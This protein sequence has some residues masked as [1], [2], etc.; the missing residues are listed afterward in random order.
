MENRIFHFTDYYGLDE[1]N[2]ISISDMWNVLKEIATDVETIGLEMTND[3]K[4]HLSTYAKQRTP[5]IATLIEEGK[6]NVGPDA[7]KYCLAGE[8]LSYCSDWMNVSGIT[9]NE[10]VTGLTLTYTGSAGEHQLLKAGDLSFSMTVRVDTYSYEMIITADRYVLDHDT[11]TNFLVTVNTYKNETELIDSFV[12][13]S[14]ATYSKSNN[15][16]SY[17]TYPNQSNGTVYGINTTD[18]DKTSRL[19]ATWA[20]EYGTVSNS[21]NFT[22]KHVVYDFVWV[23]NELSGITKENAYNETQQKTIAYTSN[24]PS[25]TLENKTTEWVSNISLD[26]TLGVLKYT[27]RENIG[28]ETLSATYNIL[29]DNVVVGYITIVQHVIGIRTFL[30]N[31]NS[32]SAITVTIGA[33][34]TTKS[35]LEDYETNYSGIQIVPD[36]TYSWITSKNISN[37]NG[38]GYLSATTTENT[39][40]N[41]DRTANLYI[42]TGSTIGAS[43]GLMKIVQEKSAY[44]PTFYWYDS[45]T[46]SATTLTVN[47]ADTTTG[48]IV[49]RNNYQGITWQ[50][51]SSEANWIT[52]VTLTQPNNDGNFTATFN[53]NPDTQDRTGRINIVYTGDNSVVGT[54]DI[55]QKEKHIPYTFYWGG[56]GT[57]S[58]TTITIESGDTIATEIYRNTY[59]GFTLEVAGSSSWIQTATASNYQGSGTFSATCQPNETYADR[60]EVVNV[61]YD[62]NTVGTIKVTQKK[63]GTYEFYWGNSNLPTTAVTVNSGIVSTYK[64][65]TNTYPNIKVSALTDSWVTSAVL[66][67]P[68]GGGRFDLTFPENLHTTDRT[69]E[70]NILYDNGSEDTLIGTFNLTQRKGYFLFYWVDVATSQSLTS[71]TTVGVASSDTSANIYYFNTYPEI[72]SNII[73]SPWITGATLNDETGHAAYNG[74]MQTRFYANADESPRNGQINITYSGETVGMAKLTQSGATY[75]FYWG[76]TGT[77]TTTGLTAASSDTSVSISYRNDYPGISLSVPSQSWVNASITSQNGNG[78]FNAQFSTNP[79]PADRTEN[80]SVMYGNKEVG[81]ITITQMAREEHHFYWQQTGT[82]TTT[83]VTSSSADT[84]ITILYRNNYQGITVSVPTDSWITSATVDNPYSDGEFTAYFTVNPD[85]TSRTEI[86]SIKYNN[87]EIAT[88]TITQERGYYYFYWENS[89][90]YYDTYGFNR[91]ITSSD[92]PY[93]S[94][95]DNLSAEI[96]STPWVNSVTLT[97]IDNKT[98]LHF[99]NTVNS[100]TTERTGAINIKHGDDV[101]GVLNLIQSGLS[102]YFNWG[103]TIDPNASAY[104]YTVSSAS[105][106]DHM[107]YVNNYPSIICVINDVDIYHDASWVTNAYLTSS[108]SDGI[109]YIDFDENDTDEERIAQINIMQGTKTVGTYKITQKAGETPTEPSFTVVWEDNNSNSIVVNENQATLTAKTNSVLQGWEIGNVYNYGGMS[110]SKTDI[111]PRRGYEGKTYVEIPYYFNDSFISGWTQIDFY[112]ELEVPY[113]ASLYITKYNSTISATWSDGTTSYMAPY[114]SGSK[115]V[116]INVS[117]VGTSW[118]LDSKPNWVTISP[119]AGTDSTANVTATWITNTGY[120]RTSERITFKL[121]DAGVSSYI[122]ISQDAA[123][124]NPSTHWLLIYGNDSSAATPNYINSDG[125]VQI[126]VKYGLIGDYSNPIDITSGSTFIYSD[127]TI[128]YIAL[129]ETDELYYFYP[130]KTGSTAISGVT[131][132]GYYTNNAINVEVTGSTPSWHYVSLDI[133]PSTSSITET[134]DNVRYRAIA[135]KDNGTTGDVSS[136]IFCIWALSGVSDCAS[137]DSYGYVTKTSN[138]S[139]DK[140]GTVHASLN[141]KTGGVTLHATA[142]VIIKHEY[143]YSIT[144]YTGTTG[145]QTATTVDSGS[146]SI[147]ARVI[148]DYQGWVIDSTTDSW[149]RVSPTGNTTSGTTNI[150]INI[151]ANP[152]TSQRIGYAIFNGDVEGST[153]IEITQRPKYELP[154]SIV[155][156]SGTSGTYTTANVGSAVTVFSAIVSALNQTWTEGS[157]TSEWIEVFPTGGTDGVTQINVRVYANDSIATRTGYVWFEGASGD[158]CYIEVNQEAKYVPPTEKYFHWFERGSETA[159]TAHVSGEQQSSGCTFRTNHTTISSLTRWDSDVDWISSILI[160]YYPSSEIGDFE[161]AISANTT[162][163]P[164]RTGVISVYGDDDSLIGTFTIRQN[165][166]VPTRTLTI[167]GDGQDVYVFIDGEY[168]GVDWGQCSFTLEPLNGSGQITYISQSS[169]IRPGSV[170]NF[171]ATGEIEITNVSTAATSITLQIV[172]VNFDNHTG[173]FESNTSSGDWDGII[174]GIGKSIPVTIDNFD[175][176]FSAGSDASH[177][178]DGGSESNYVLTFTPDA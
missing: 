25:L 59:P 140:T 116:N 16:I 4:N 37:I 9:F 56:T 54:I 119:T 78:T 98:V 96:D 72:E 145:I 57:D 177:T 173:V 48:A 169:V 62:G 114:S 61:K 73:S 105:T 87:T 7:D 49:Y 10:Y 107:Y 70:I 68:T 5:G 44:T 122:N 142:E 51:D 162:T 14:A 52:N 6:I 99:T 88:I 46:I 65:Y 121:A 109:M 164:F 95:Y 8:D 130:Y 97:V 11:S 113:I 136:N 35:V 58:A 175:V 151:D 135:T 124:Y 22:V 29:N 171:E 103:T 19:T 110:V 53:V 24:Y 133:I 3:A 149:L 76:N 161:C 15:Y 89:S 36:T 115:N 55:T 147:N 174:M 148:A 159:V 26:T 170:I 112:P 108:N 50:R 12:V 33:S 106:D 123:P 82:S 131:S 43:V 34:A 156:Y 74:L 21:V 18:E 86:V 137:I 85:V 45:G 30:W 91:T 172:D 71:G 101:V 75:H 42:C 132:A 125:S 141:Y 129:D 104:S 39:D 160:N 152:S 90:T 176:N 153:S 168:A 1:N 40:V 69:E 63:K 146:T 38:N 2:V 157:L 166:Y 32:S 154:H 23:E 102:Y 94:N 163:A 111:S 83:A 41:N 77:Y 84:S 117:P 165:I 79:N 93:I 144:A 138:P 80:I 60:N 31:K 128:G 178:I 67:N 27:L 134:N 13:T 120:T 100:Q 17:Q 66:S 150:T 118:V 92:V 167:D 47:S 81:T 139:S 158:S 127:D 126:N 155:A 64:N 20:G 143:E 28:Y